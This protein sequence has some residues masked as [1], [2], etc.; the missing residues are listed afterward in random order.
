MK[1]ILYI[2]YKLPS[3]TTTFVY[4]EVQALRNAGYQIKTVSMNKPH[5][6]EVHSEALCVYETTTYLDQVGF[7]YKLLSQIKL[8]INKPGT[9]LRLFWIVFSEKEIDGYKDRLRLL[10]HFIGAGYLYEL[11]KHNPINHIQAAFLSGP[12]SIAF[13][14]SQYLQ[15]PYSFTIHASNIFIDPIMLGRKLL[16]SK[17]IVTISQYNKQYLLKKYGKT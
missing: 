11:L 13:F 15:V 1:H 7:F 4:R 6:N 5:L 2:S 17:K 9:F 16:T 3:V 8:A 10:W 12:A 14:L